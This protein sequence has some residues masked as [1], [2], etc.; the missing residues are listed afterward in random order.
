MSLLKE[1][2]QDKSL[3]EISFFGSHD[4]NTFTIENSI[5]TDFA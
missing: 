2:I 5:F 1:H 3:T 4:S